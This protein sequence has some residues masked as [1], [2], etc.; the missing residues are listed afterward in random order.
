MDE[1]SCNTKF[2]DLSKKFE[3][4]IENETLENL[5][6]LLSRSEMTTNA[7]NTVQNQD[8][9]QSIDLNDQAPLPAQNKHLEN[10]IL[11]ESTIE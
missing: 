10:Q 7:D 11:Y 5:L 2:E 9:V 6:P 8:L 4:V 1:V 3:E